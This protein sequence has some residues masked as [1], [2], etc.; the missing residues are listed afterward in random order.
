MVAPVPIAAP[1]TRAYAAPTR[2]PVDIS[3][4]NGFL[5][6][7]G[8]FAEDWI[9]GVQ[10]DASL[11]HYTDL[12]GLVGILTTGDLWLTHSRFSNDEQEL[13]HGYALARRVIEDSRTS[14]VGPDWPSFLDMVSEHLRDVPTQGVFITCFCKGEN[15][16]SQWRGYGA[17][18]AGVS[19][20]LRPRQFNLV[21]GPDSPE[22]GLMR[23]WRVFYAADTQRQLLSTALSFAFQSAADNATRA[24]R[25]ADAIE[26]F[27]PTFKNADFQSEDE[28]RLIFTPPPRCTVK[29]HFRVARGMVMPYYSLREL[30]LGRQRLPITGITVGPSPNRA[31]NVESIRML[32][33]TFDY[34]DV[35]VVASPTPYRG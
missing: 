23:L 22:H 12:A 2:A 5:L 25:A 24:S 13:T 1:P 20:Q 9:Y 14:L 27:V 34:A 7:V 16:L 11:Y 26:F 29:P 31:V 17:N 28:C 30:S 8:S 18:G 21:T 3:W 35:P 15:L 33:E 6:N 10:P 19:I 32:L 4:L